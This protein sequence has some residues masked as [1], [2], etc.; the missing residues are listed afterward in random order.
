MNIMY[1][2]I[3]EMES[4]NGTANDSIHGGG[5]YNDDHIGHEVNNFTNH[6][7][8]FW[9]FVQSKND[10][11]NIAEH[12]DCS[13]NAEYVDDVLVVWVIRKR[14]IVGFYKNARVYKK[15]QFL[16]DS[17][18]SERVYLDY[19]IT[20]N[21]AI[22]IPRFERT[23][24][25]DYPSVARNT[26][27][28]EEDTN[29]KVENY[30]SSYLTARKASIE[31][32]ESPLVGSER[33]AVV[34]IRENQGVFRKR[35]LKKFSTKCCLCGV[36]LP[37]LLIASHIKPWSRSDDNEKL[38]YENGLLLCPIHDKLFDSGYISFNDDGSILISPLLTGMNLIF[39]NVKSEMHLK[40]EI[41]SAEM[42]QYLEYHRKNIY[43]R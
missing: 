33:E 16:P 10:T 20:S 11:I 22:I 8:S 13:Q 25:I 32:I 24:E 26:W 29:K 9:G 41:I 27:F 4:Y 34:K 21:E 15:K 2:N 17:F 42:K 39:T 43:K 31:A 7:G 28:G 40:E 23:F 18:L 36:T 19:N 12:F 1:C 14:Y 38:S 37:D 6:N 5:S 3:G 30:L 35:M